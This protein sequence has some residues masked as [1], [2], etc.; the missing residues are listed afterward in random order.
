MVPEVGGE[1]LVHT[2]GGGRGILMRHPT[3]GAQY[4][5]TTALLLFPGFLEGVTLPGAAFLSHGLAPLEGEME[6]AGR[7]LGGE[8]DTWPHRLLW[9]C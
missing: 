4:I 6:A 1:A 2:P 5:S 7:S 8:H 9:A 3:L